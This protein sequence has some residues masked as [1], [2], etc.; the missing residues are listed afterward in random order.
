LLGKHR[1][2]YRTCREKAKAQPTVDE[3]N[4]GNKRYM[5]GHEHRGARLLADGKLLKGM[6]GT[7]RLDDHNS[8]MLSNPLELGDGFRSAVH[9]K[10]GFASNVAR[11]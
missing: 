4:R 1:G 10:V 5:R 7:T 6:A 9:R 3:C 8:A 11:I 2:Y